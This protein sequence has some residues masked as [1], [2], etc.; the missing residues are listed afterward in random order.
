[1]N[2]VEAADNFQCVPPYNWNHNSPIFDP[3][4]KAVVSVP[5]RMHANLCVGI[6]KNYEV[7]STRCLYQVHD[8]YD[9]VGSLRYYQCSLGGNCLGRGM[10]SNPSRTSVD[11]NTDRICFSF[12]SFDHD[13]GNASI[14]M[15]YGPK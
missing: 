4:S 12:D 14:D 1:M 6:N 13:S 15:I 10:F 11:F 3:R 8:K 5:P 9:S 7:K 2:D